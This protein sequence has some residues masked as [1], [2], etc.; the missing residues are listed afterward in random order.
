LKA[1]LRKG[2]AKVTLATFNV[3]NFFIRYKFA[4]TYP[5]DLSAKS[6]P[7]PVLKERCKSAGSYGNVNRAEDACGYFHSRLTEY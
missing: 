6:S 5:G 3:N 7:D 4:K 1:Q 2:S